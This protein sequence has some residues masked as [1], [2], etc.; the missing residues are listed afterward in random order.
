VGKWGG[1][2]AAILAVQ[3]LALGDG[4]LAARLAEYKVEL[5]E[6]VEEKSERLNDKMK[7]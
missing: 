5:A 7:K 3:I 1:E 4:R 6:G 2:N